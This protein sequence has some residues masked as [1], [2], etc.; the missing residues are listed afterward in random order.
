[1][2]S[3][4]PGPRS[5]ERLPGVLRPSPPNSIPQPEALLCR[6]LTWTCHPDG[7]TGQNFKTGKQGAH[8][9][10]Q[11]ILWVSVTSRARASSTMVLESKGLLSTKRREGHKRRMGVA[12]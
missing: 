9:D 4:S 12:L 5:I 11:G 7:S 1:M 8:L 2:P 3:Q 10:G 6:V